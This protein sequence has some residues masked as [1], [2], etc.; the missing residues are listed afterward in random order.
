MSFSLLDKFLG[1]A[2][3]ALLI[4]VTL[5]AFQKANLRADL[6]EAQAQNAAYMAANDEWAY[7]VE[8]QNKEVEGLTQAAQAREKAAREAVKA[9]DGRAGAYQAKA[10]S[11]D[12]KTA[13][14]GADAC[15]TIDGLVNDYLRS[16]Q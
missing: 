4:L 15:A 11:L 3:T 10:A 7:Q 13:P 5:L 16:N 6:A 1:G 8:A 2:L 9:A 12:R 14:S